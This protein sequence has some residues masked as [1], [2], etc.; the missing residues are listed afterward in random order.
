LVTIVI[1]AIV[2]VSMLGGSRAAAVPDEFSGAEKVD[3][4]MA[5]FFD[6]FSE[7]FD[8]LGIDV[9]FAMY[10]SDFNPRYMIMIMEGEGLAG[11]GNLGQEFGTGFAGGM[12]AQVDMSEAIEETVGSTEYVCVPATG[13]QFSQVGGKIAMCIYLD[14]E[15]A[16]IVMAFRY[17]DLNG[18]MDKTQELHDQVVD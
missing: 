8:E 6:A 12:G 10:G 18:L 5:D 7:P 4:P 13:Q 16:G 11:G 17:E 15:Q 9:T 1:L 3:G 14:G 2:F